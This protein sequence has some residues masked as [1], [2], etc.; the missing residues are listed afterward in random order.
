MLYE[1][2]MIRMLSVTVAPGETEPSSSLAVNLHH[3]S[4]GMRASDG[5]GKEIVLPLPA[6]FEMPLILKLPAQ[7]AH[8]DRNVDTS[9]I[10]G[11]RIELKQGFPK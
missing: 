9:P 5:E 11:T 1:D 7:P 6:T 4:A 2:D 8:A 10:H 3:R